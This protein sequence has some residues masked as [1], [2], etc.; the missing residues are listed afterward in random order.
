MDSPRAEYASW[1]QDLVR[2]PQA[3][4]PQESAYRLE[5]RTA[6]AKWRAAAFG[7]LGL[8]D[9]YLDGDLEVHGSL[10]A[11][12][13]DGIRSRSF[14]PNALA[15]LRDRWHEW[16]HSNTILAH[17]RANASY[18]YGLGLD[19]YRL[20]LDE[21][22]IYTCAYW[23]EGTQTLEDAQRAKVEHVCRKL[24]LS[25]GDSVI[26]IGCG[27]GGF[28]FNALEHHD[29]RVTGLNIAPEQA[30]YVRGEIERRQLG[31]S[32][33]VV[34][35]D[36]RGAPLGEF[37]KV[38]SIGVLEHAGRGQLRE[39][40]QAH[41][42]FLKPGGL[43]L[44]H[45]IGHLGP[46]TTDTFVREHVFPGGW[47]PALSEVLEAMYQTGLEVLD[48]E[49][50]RPHYALTLDAWAERFD[51]N[52]PRIQAIDPARFDERFLR[53]WRIYLYGCAEMYRLPEGE[54]QLFQVVFSRGAASRD[55][56]PLTRD[57]IY[58]PRGP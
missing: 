26:D 17:A 35:A 34:E 28:M 58:Q 56:W 9:A 33:R 48:V 2:S 30:S 22:L 18:H 27:F 29:V 49:N 39:A 42:R 21:S 32:L 4:R 43:G 57:F 14:K 41:A 40:V 15:R 44:T 55:T 36:F 16:I 11:A 8:I 1:S 45:F 10:R 19:F 52:W 20:W 7:H 12:I 46:T 54:L 31:E 5:F 51:R 3:N 23:K 24:R 37:D 13:V 50:L 38:A 47:I 53:I 25:P 6:R